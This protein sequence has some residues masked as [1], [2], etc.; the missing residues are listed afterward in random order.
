MNLTSTARGRLF[1]FGALYFA[2]GV[3]WGF[4]ATPL[5]LY[6]TNQG[7][8]EAAIGEV[9]ALSYLPWSFKLLLAP[10]SDAVNLGRL[11]RR[12]PWILAA[13]LGMAATLLVLAGLDPRD[14]MP[15]FLGLIFLHNVFAA[16]QDVGVD[17]LAVE[18]LGEHERGTANSVMWA[19]KYL[20]VAAGGKGFAS[21]GA[22]LGW[23][24]L[25]LVMAALVLVMAVLPALVR[26]P[27]RIPLPAPPRARWRF[28]PVDW[29]IHL[30][31]LAAL[32]GAYPLYR[33]GGPV[34]VIWHA[35]FVGVLLAALR[36]FVRGATPLRSQVIAVT[37]RSFTLRATFFGMILFLL[38]PS[39]AGL[40]YPMGV[41]LLKNQLGYT[42][43][44]I[45][46]LNGAIS[47][48]ASAAGALAGGILSD[49]IGRRRA[50][51]LFALITAGGYLAFGLL[52]GL[53][54]SR[55]FV[56]S[57]MVLAALVEGMLSST[58]LPLAMDLSNPA[59]S[60]TQFTSYMAL[61]NWKNSW[62]ALLGGYLSAGRLS[63][64]GMYIL[65]AFAQVAPLLLLPLVNPEEA[66]R[67]FR[68]EQEGDGAA[69][70]A[71]EAGA[72]A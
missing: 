13:E 27:P 22:A 2:Q 69:S 60:G 8:G 1:F 61:Q 36:T 64:P 12:R 25:F 40:L 59:V 3:P 68:K 67:A 50:I 11:G 56:Y 7:L 39:A 52:P 46:T 35:I 47:T 29:A 62:N 30:A 28:R 42:D 44:E 14:S 23:R 16:A 32:C 63:A 72:T 51:L 5:A 17:A 55:A 18:I 37:L 43:D 34:P 31:A 49:F 66:K 70:G 71:P 26:E 10:I 24:A 4:I 33:W 41:P 38:A 54:G 48:V 45:S 21:I 9:L 6:L 65:A 15:I 53:W 57:I 19:A 58:F 20:G